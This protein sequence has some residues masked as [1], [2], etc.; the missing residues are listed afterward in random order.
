MKSSTIE[1]NAATTISI[2]SA[3]LSAGLLLTVVLKYRSVRKADISDDDN[4]DNLEDIKIQLAPYEVG[5][6]LE[7]LPSSSTITFFEGIINQAKLYRKVTSILENNPWLAGRLVRRK[8]NG[9]SYLQY[10]KSDITEAV[11]S[12]IFRSVTHDDLHEKLSHREIRKVVQLYT[13]KKGAEC[14]NKKEPLFKV[15]LIVTGSKSCAL[16]VSICHVVGDGATRNA[17]YRMLS[18]D[19]PVTALNPRRDF[20]F[21]SKVQAVSPLT[22]DSL[23]DMGSIYYLRDIIIRKLFYRH[24]ALLVHF[25][26][27]WI[28]EEKRKY[29]SSLATTSTTDID[30]NNSLSTPMPSFIST[31]DIITS[32]IM[33]TLKCDIGFLSINYR[34]RIPDITVEHAGNYVLPIAYQP[35][36]F[37][38]PALIRAS[39][40]TYGRAIS[41]E[42]RWKKFMK[43]MYFITNWATFYR[44][45]I[46]D[47]C[48]EVRLLPIEHLSKFAQVIFKSSP[49]QYSWLS[50]NFDPSLYE[51]LQHRLNH[52]SNSIEVE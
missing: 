38:T 12:E 49:T 47:G 41:K 10:N 37:A 52:E 2:V 44:E 11:V 9:L 7:N 30:Q 31:N 48:Q 29:L 14:Y 50:S 33:Q 20:E 15:T 8:S 22:S 4:K 40:Q 45:L 25:N 19:Q 13:V 24:T 27:D 17:V 43:N 46:F 3:V 16:V 39:L 6:Q 18:D 1:W 28:D 5:P 21:K 42:L 26:Q 34:N 51:Q 23:A 36:D 32:W 35:E